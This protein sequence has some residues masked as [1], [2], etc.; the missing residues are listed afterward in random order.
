MVWKDAQWKRYVKC[1]RGGCVRCDGVKAVE[2][3]K[4][5]IGMA[6]V[7]PLAQNL[8]FFTYCGT[9]YLFGLF[10]GFWE[11]LN[12][13]TQIPPFHCT[14]QI[15]RHF[16][17]QA[18]FYAISLHRPNFTPFHCTCQML[19]VMNTSNRP[20][21]KSVICPERYER[22]GGWLKV[23][24]SNKSIITI[25]QDWLCDD[26]RNESSELVNSTSVIDT[27]LHFLTSNY[28]RE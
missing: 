24:W 18:K 21:C 20:D 9:K 16:I 8:H 19:P 1:F 7:A 5:Y 27:S 6:K 11:A 22:E 13:N 2:I 4:N 23:W 14:G 12:Q 28:I 17:A 3:W 15:L 25:V 26:S 10:G